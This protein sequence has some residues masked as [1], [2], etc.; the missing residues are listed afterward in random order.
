MY[1]SIHKLNGIAI[2]ILENS[3][4]RV[5][6][7]RCRKRSRGAH[8]LPMESKRETTGREGGREAFLIRAQE[9]KLCEQ[10][11][12]VVGFP[13]TPSE[14]AMIPTKSDGAD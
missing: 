1:C 5:H 2:Q 11:L 6:S 3:N 8:N 9:A 14:S 7:L 10:K 13:P 4:L 12:F